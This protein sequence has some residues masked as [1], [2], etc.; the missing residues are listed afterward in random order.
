MSRTRHILLTLA[1]LVATILQADV[2]WR[3]P[4]SADSSMRQ[5]GGTRVFNTSVEINGAPGKLSLF[6]FDRGAREIATTLAREIGIKPPAY[7]RGYLLT[8]V[9]RKT[10]R[11]LFILPS[12]ANTESSLTLLFEQPLSNTADARTP[13][14]TWPAPLPQLDATPIFTAYSS[15]THTTFA[16]GHTRADPATATDSAINALKQNG[17]HESGTGTPTFKLCTSGNKIC[18]VMATSNP[19]SDESQITLLMREG[20]NR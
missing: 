2:F 12:A 7:S 10:L 20:A 4:R 9:E 5:A 13:P 6:A 17:W 18:I 11:R 8:H 1:L 14:T 3:L 16:T 15:A 19:E